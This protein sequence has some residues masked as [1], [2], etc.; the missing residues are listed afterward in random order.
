MWTEAVALSRI[1]RR[2]HVA[3]FFGIA[4]LMSASPRR[5][6]DSLPSK[7]KDLGYGQ[8]VIGALWAVA[9]IT[10]IGLFS[11]SQRILSALTI[12]VRLDLGVCRFCCPLDW[13]RFV[14]RRTLAV[15]DF[16]GSARYFLRPISCAVHRIHSL[17]IS[18]RRLT[19]E[20]KR[21]TR[22]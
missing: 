19:A 11:Q 8:T 17:S 7:M 10:E 22:P 15:L 2:K 1:L 6:M 12:R 14:G 16:P 18:A 9:V 21:C 5:T 4:L 20:A 13:D 3:V